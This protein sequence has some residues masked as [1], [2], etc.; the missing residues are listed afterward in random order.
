[1]KIGILDGFTLFQNDINKNV[2][3]QFGEVIYLDRI[4]NQIIPE[5]ILDSEILITNKFVLNRE[6]IPQF[7]NLKKIIVSA[8]G[9]NCIDSE[10]CKEKNIPVRNVPGYGTE[11]VAQ[12]AFSLILH[13][14]NHVALHMDSVRKGD[15][16]K[17]PDFCYQIKPI[18]ELKDKTLG[19]IGLG[20]IG[21]AT[22]KIAE[23]F[24][25]KIIYSHTKDLKNQYPYKNLDQLFSESDFISLSCPAT[26]DN[27]GFI[28]AEAFSKMKKNAVLINTARGLLINEN[29][30]ADAL[31]SNKIAAA[32]LDVLETEPPSANNPLIHLDN[33][34]ITPH[35]AWMSYEA[36]MRIIDI[37]NY[38]LRGKSEA[39]K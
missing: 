22:A 18:I 21:K 33:C 8:T 17:N 29:D 11:S 2:F 39:N 14:T 26:K 7:K 9:I 3:N 35:N 25:M 15:W 13:Y 20:A 28:N 5:N 10:Y 19:I 12:H 6:N 34:F 23:A 24:G 1:M 4:E 38:E 37:I 31:K 32:L 36:R 30:L 16:T 27:I